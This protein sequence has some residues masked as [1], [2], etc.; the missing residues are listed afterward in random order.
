MNTET[1]FSPAEKTRMENSSSERETP[2]LSSSEALTQEKRPNN[3]PPQENGKPDSPVK[4]SESRLYADEPAKRSKAQT[5]FL[6]TTLLLLAVFIMCAF[7]AALLRLS[8]AAGKRK[9]WHNTAMYL[10]TLGCAVVSVFYVLYVFFLLFPDFLVEMA[11]LIETQNETVHRMAVRVKSLALLLSLSAAASIIAVFFFTEDAWFRRLFEKMKLPYVKE[12]VFG[13]NLDSIP[14]YLH[15]LSFFTALL[16]ATKYLLDLYQEKNNNKTYEKRIAKSNGT[17]R[18]LRA[19]LFGETA[20]KTTLESAKKRMGFELEDDDLLNISGEKDARALANSIFRKLAERGKDAIYPHDIEYLFPEEKN[21]IV[22]A[23]GGRHTGC[24][25]LKMLRKYIVSYYKERTNLKK[26]LRNHTRMYKKFTAVVFAIVLVISALLFKSTNIG[27]KV[28]VYKSAF[29]VGMVA[30]LGFVFAE[31][32]QDMFKTLTFTFVLH[33]F[34]C[35]DYITFGGKDYIVDQI[36]ILTV[37][38]TD[39]LSSATCYLSTKSLVGKDFLNHSRSGEYIEHVSVLVQPVNQ[40]APEELKKAVQDCIKKD[41]SDFTGFVS[42]ENVEFQKNTMRISLAVEHTDNIGIR[43][44]ACERKT[45][46]GTHVQESLEKTGLVL[47]E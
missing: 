22:G 21:E 30:T 11:S 29:S 6:E 35:G 32:P 19:L 8:V 43:G 38:M 28:D 13:T 36:T 7:P 41:A 2:T 10:G 26:S 39:V 47:A 40:A 37:K 3:T 42:L 33:P 27:G 25:S 34:D 31:I 12:T 1:A 9:E 18:T 17:G 16:A 44:E 5:D 46:L 4:R 23:M 20:E 15:E 14:V 45:R 24:V